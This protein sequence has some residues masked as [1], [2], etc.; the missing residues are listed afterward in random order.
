MGMPHVTTLPSYL[1]AGDEAYDE[2][3][4]ARILR[5]LLAALEY[6]HS[7][8][9]IHRDVRLQS[10]LMDARQ[11]R[12]HDFGSC[13]EL[14]HGE[15]LVEKCGSP[16]LMAP[17]MLQMR[18][19][20]QKVDM[21]AMGV[22]SYVLLY[23]VHPYPLS[24]GM[25]SAVSGEPLPNFHPSKRLDH[26]KTKVSSAAER[27]VRKLLERQRSKR[28][29]TAMA[30][31]SDFIRG[32]HLD[33]FHLEGPSSLVPQLDLAEEI[34]WVMDGTTEG[35]HELDD[36]LMRLA[37]NAGRYEPTYRTKRST[38]K[39]SSSTA[40]TQLSA[41]GSDLEAISESQRS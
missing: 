15:L 41:S 5:Q 21:W 20:N 14:R 39:E 28:A 31:N 27:F 25:E 2:R 17:E 40:S 38:S 32:N 22:L 35:T 33:L 16:M 11:L 6:M 13:V 3:C 1:R 26:V 8:S 37:C 30:R 4:L 23:G 34:Y 24:E 29:N 9:V 10:C 19:Y 7:L 36:T 18:P 12:L